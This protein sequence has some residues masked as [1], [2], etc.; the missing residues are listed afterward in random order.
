MAKVLIVDDS[1]TEMLRMTRFLEK[2]G[3]TVITAENGENGVKVAEA[4]LPDVVLMDI[5][6]PGVDGLA[7]TKSMSSAW[8]KAVRG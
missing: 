4:E 3:H 7:A 5:R 8:P 2:Q 1:Q 6:M